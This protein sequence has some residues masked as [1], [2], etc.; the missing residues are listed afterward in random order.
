M[1]DTSESNSNPWSMTICYGTI[2]VTGVL[3]FGLVYRREHVNMNPAAL[4]GFS[5]VL[6]GK[7]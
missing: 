7:S 5:V 3:V 6:R 4:G 1:W 2:L